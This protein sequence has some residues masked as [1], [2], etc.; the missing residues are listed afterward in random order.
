MVSSLGVAAPLVFVL[1]WAVLTPAL[2]S[3]TLLALAAG[4]SFGPVGGTL[5]G[6]AGATLGGV[7]AF[8]IARR[9]G[10]TAAEQLGGPR[11][12]QVKRRIERRGF[13]AVLSAR[14]AP[15]VPA[16]L[17]NYACGLSRVRLRDFVAGN[18]LGG[19]PRM[20][21]YASLGASGGHLASGPALLGVALIAVLALAVPAAM[22]WRRLRP[23][24]A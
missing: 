21:A 16:T 7:L 4:L 1:V 8:A 3:G 9:F 24:A 11:L 6:I 15:G 20:L 2:A 14:M 22:L 10:R 19:A 23:V 5:V 17:L 13:L 18:A 12:H